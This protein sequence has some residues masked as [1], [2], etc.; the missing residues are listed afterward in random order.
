[1]SGKSN[2]KK[3]RPG[4][5]VGRKLAITMF[6]LVVAAVTVIV[7]LAMRSGVGTLSSRSGVIEPDE[8]KIRAFEEAAAAETETEKPEE[9]EEP[10]DPHLVAAQKV[11]DGMSLEEK[12]YQLFITSPDKLTGRI[13]TS[14]AEGTLAEQLQAMPI[15]GLILYEANVYS[16]DQVRTMLTGVQENAKVPLLIGIDGEPGNDEGLSKFGITEAFQ[17][18]SVYG[19]NVDEAGIR[20]VGKTLGSDMKAVGFNVDFAPVADVLTDGANTEV[21]DRSFGSDPMIV[22]SMV[23][24]MISGLHESEMIACAKHFPGLGSTVYSTAYSAVASNRSMDELRQTELRPFY[25]AM[26]ADTDMIMVSH[27]RFPSVVE[28]DLPSSLSPI[29]IQE[30]LRGEMGYQGVVIT[31]SF[32]KKAISDNYS[33]AEAAVLAIQAGCDMILLPEDLEQAAE[34]ILTA[35]ENGDIREDRINE[36]VLRIL[37]LKSR[38]GLLGTVS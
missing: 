19:E 28:G 35:I 31:D 37:T 17:S 12:V 36:S 34:G 18:A 23:R 32:Q 6:T 7:V 27:L 10:E 20:Q 22:S 24:E 29:I 11:L 5:T 30:I 26:E 8:E 13:G 3:K 33:A 4:N 9:T 21:G 2:P 1:M 15:G 38:Y 14:E 25:A 16:A